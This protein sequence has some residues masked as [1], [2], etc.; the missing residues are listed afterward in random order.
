[1]NSRTALTNLA[2]LSLVALGGCSSP[3]LPSQDA[4]LDRA[5]QDAAPAMDASDDA[6][7][8]MDAA[9]D[10]VSPGDSAA[11]ATPDAAPDAEEEDAGPETG[12]TLT[13]VLN[14]LTIERS[15]TPTLAGFNLDGIFSTP[16]TPRSCGRGDVG[17]TLDLDQNI[18]SAMVDPATGRA[19]GAASP[20]AF[21][22]TCVGGVDNVLPEIADF[23]MTNAGQDVRAN[24][25]RMIDTGE[26]AF[27]V[28]V[29]GVDD[30]SDDPS[31]T[32]R[33]YEAFPTFS[34]G[35]TSVVADR[36]YAVAQS[37]LVAGATSID[38]ARFQVRASIV[39]GRIIPR[40]GSALRLPVGPGVEVDVNSAILRANIA[41]TALSNGNLGG[42]AR[43]GQ[44]YDAVV[45]MNPSLA[46]IAVFAIAQF[47]DLEEPIPTPGGAAGFCARTAARPPQFGNIGIGATFSAVRAT[48]SA[49]PVAARAPG[50]CGSM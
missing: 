27:V 12:R 14:R 18:A 24:S 9:L 13:F 30:L 40:A 22:A 36:E 34:T 46:P 29:S 20:C 17:S 19:T 38:Q 43:G 49:M 1:M 23:V 45:M 35:C 10:V 28:R 50:A 2:L 6:R 41:E 5:A 31:V 33:V 8:G 11:D 37:S 44:F 15:G 21:G 32:M 47:V 16:S 3:T 26:L 25:Q 48:V 39:G 4:A 7:G 42:F